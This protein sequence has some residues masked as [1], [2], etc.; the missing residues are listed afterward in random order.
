ME[1]DLKFNPVNGGIDC[2]FNGE[3]IGG[4]GNLI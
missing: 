2:S 1:K 3:H 4:D